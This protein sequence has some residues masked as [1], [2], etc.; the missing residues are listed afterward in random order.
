MEKY[1]IGTDASMAVHINNICERRYVSV[2]EKRR[3]MVPTN[4][5][6]VLIH[7]YQKIDSELALPT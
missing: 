7:G 6:I 4:L 2:Q 3:Y 5:G 1:G